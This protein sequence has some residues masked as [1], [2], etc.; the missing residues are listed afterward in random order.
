MV[1]G[2]DE[3]NDDVRVPSPFETFV[4]WLGPPRGYTLTRWIILRLLG[5]VYA[6]AFLGIVF[7]GLPLI[8][9]HGLTPAA[10]YLDQ[11]RH[12]GQ[13]FWDVPTIFFASDTDTMLM[14][15]AYV[16]LALSI[17]VAIG[18]ANLPILAILWLLYGSFER[19]GQ[20]W[21]SFG[22][23]IQLLET[24]LIAALLAHPWD[25]RPLAARPP[26]TTAIVLMRW[27]AFRIMLGAGLI[28]LRG[29]DCWRALTCLD[30]HFETQP[31]PNPL[32]PWFHHQPHVV[33]AIGVAFNHVVEVVAPWFVFGPRRLRLIAGCLMVAFQVV[34]VL[35]G[36]LAFLNWLTLVPLLACFD[37]DALLASLPKRAR[38][39]LASKLPARP[40]RSGSELA[41][42]FG[43]SLLVIILWEVLTGWLG[44]PVQLVLGV[45]LVIAACIVLRKRDLH[46]L[47]IGAFAALVAVKSIAVVEN[48]A[49]SHQAMNRNYDRLELVNT[50]GAFGS[51]G[52][53]R[54]ELVIEG[55]LDAD[56]STATWH[57]YELPCKP[58]DV[59]RRPCVLGP[60]HRRL[61]WLIWFAAM[62]ERPPYLWVYTLAWKL[63]DG[64]RTI[65]E[66]FAVDPFAGRA[67]RWLRIR[68]FVYRFAPSGSS[69]WWVRSDEEPW[70]EPVSKDSPVFREVFDQYGAP[71]PSEH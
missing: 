1:L 10:S 24:G 16:G 71:S 41:T 26:P 63:L 20:D 35:S 51:V 68:R 36:N 27:L 60:Y 62:A 14:T 69:D 18:Y 61:D 54:H 12:A 7:Q 47:A 15:C 6:F 59:M 66:L 2:D 40:A 50:Y 46:Q 32:S 56:P 22:W 25:P 49:G 42:A 19:V 44:A 52:A 5:V 45:A 53:T 3:G 33:H 31:I 55:T 4:A 43:I 58:G 28:K 11:L 9:S 48:L 30:S 70:L 21:W 65:R 67:P 57:A 23:E 8:G 37:D 38:N 64:D 39:W 34:L 17:V 29:D 13:T